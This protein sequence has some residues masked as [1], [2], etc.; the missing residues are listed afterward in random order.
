[1]F[2]QMTHPLGPLLLSSRR[3]VHWIL[4]LQ[5][6]RMGLSEIEKELCKA[7]YRLEIGVGVQSQYFSQLKWKKH[8]SIR[9]FSSWQNDSRCVFSK[10][11]SFRPISLPRST[12]TRTHQTLMCSEGLMWWGTIEQNVGRKSHQC[13]DLKEQ[14]CIYSQAIINLR[15]GIRRNNSDL[16]NSAKFHLNDLFFGRHHV[17]YQNIAIFDTLQYHYMLCSRGE[18]GLGCKCVHFCKWK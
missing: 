10:S 8:Y 15:Y 3:V 1:M 7:I 4:R 6:E 13:R 2:C 18:S 11:I 5:T 9:C 17:H 16:V 14:V 12:W